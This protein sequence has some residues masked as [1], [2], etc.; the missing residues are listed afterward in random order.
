MS[1]GAR[2]ERIAFLIIWVFIFFYV[3]KK[4][5][6]RNVFIMTI[7]AVLGILL[8]NSIGVIRASSSIS[9]SEVFGAMFSS[10]SSNIL[11]NMLGEFGSAL[12]TLAVTVK[13]VPIA[14]S[15]GY[16][17][18]YLAGILSIVPTLAT[19][20]GFG[21]ATMY[22]SKLSG[23]TYFGGSYLGELY[24]N[25]SW[26]GSLV[27]IVIGIIVSRAQSYIYAT[28]TDGNITK[29]GVFAAIVMISLILFVRGYFTDMVQ[30]LV[31]TWV[32]LYFVN[33]RPLTIGRN[34]I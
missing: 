26:L 34:A 27:C 15:W 25:F 31:W 16:G 1:T 21:D 18:S 9:I 4:M 6:L 32:L 10:D 30:K 2:Q 33:D 13:Q 11:G 8:V 24:Y 3:S 14:C 23:V 5:R 19:R 12:T 17:D 20:L 22:I 29:K 28:D 7:L